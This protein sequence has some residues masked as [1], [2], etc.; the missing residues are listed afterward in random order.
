MNTAWSGTGRS[1]VC[2]EDCQPRRLAMY[3]LNGLFGLSKTDFVPLQIGFDRRD[4][5]ARIIR[6]LLPF[7]LRRRH[8]VDSE[9]SQDQVELCSA[10]GLS[11]V[12]SVAQSGEDNSLASVQDSGDN[13]S[14]VRCRRPGSKLA[15]TQVGRPRSRI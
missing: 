5:V 6:Q 14:F 7:G 2:A 13:T 9:V 15:E 12:P 4:L 3:A 10:R 8:V 11:A 1:A